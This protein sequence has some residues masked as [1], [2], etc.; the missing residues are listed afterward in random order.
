MVQ[1][2]LSALTPEPET[3]I[4]GNAVSEERSPLAEQLVVV[5]VALGTTLAPLNSTIIAVALPGVM[6]DFDVGLASAGW[7][8]TAYL[9]VMASLQPVAGKIGDKVGRRRLVLGGLTFFGLASL[10][11]AIAPNLW[12]LLG[13]RV[14][15][16]V[17]GALIVPNGVALVREVVP[18]ARRGAVFGLVGAGVA[19]AA[20][21]GPTAGSLLSE[22]AGWRIIFSINL[23]IVLPALVIGLR[24]LPAGTDRLNQGRLDVAAIVLLPLVLGI[25]ALLLSSTTRGGF[26][27]VLIAGSGAV[28]AVAAVFFW[29]ELKHP[30]PILQPR[31][32]RRRDF[33]AANAGIGLGNLAMYT[34]LLS[35]P[36]LLTSRSGSS[37]VQAGLVLSAMS[38]AM[39]IMSPL[40][41]RLIDRFGRR[42]P[43]AAGLGM[44]TLGVL[45]LAVAGPQVTLPVLLLG[46][47]L[48]GVG[49]GMA[50]PGL[51]TT[52]VE[53]VSKDKAG[54]ASGIYS[55]S[56][57]LGSIV[58]SAIL[59]GLLGADK[60]GVGSLGTVFL[61]VLV[62]AILATIASV[63]LRAR[64]EL[65]SL[66]QLRQSPIS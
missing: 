63:G 20:A 45:P 58:G 30:D 40:G 50:M 4:S 15:Q 38:V 1:K 59:A 25:T 19:L 29:R 33:A 41:G 62:S 64:P 37:I 6:D 54:V 21:L 44:L 3:N 22:A 12:L 14:L 18:E 39:A 7:L 51:Q 8:V 5:T 11:A 35:V 13:F 24:W 65:Y 42:V 31:L 32:F 56:R 53:S 23:V 9:I 46:L 43:T 36:L 52:A 61:V 34:V 66:S 47:I 57:Y 10:G 48:I 55:T 28:L 2:G 17:S 49:I 60:G 26:S 16:A 27:P